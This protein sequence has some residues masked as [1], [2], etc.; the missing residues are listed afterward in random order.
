MKKLKL[1]FLFLLIAVITCSDKEAIASQA[2]DLALQK[3]VEISNHKLVV[4]DFEI[5]GTIGCTIRYA[6]PKSKTYRDEDAYNKCFEDNTNKGPTFPGGNAPKLYPEAPDLPVYREHRALIGYFWN[7][8]DVNDPTISGDYTAAKAKL[9]IYNAVIV[10]IFSDSFGNLD[11]PYD[12]GLRRNK[13]MAYTGILPAGIKPYIDYVYGEEFYL[14][15][16]EAVSLFL[17]H[18]ADGMIHTYT[19]GI[20][21]NGAV[22]GNEKWQ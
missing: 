19:Y 5:G 21:V 17:E 2:T 9:A 14:Q 15:W 12:A 10:S 7:L 11:I 4:D 13:V 6:D 3:H 20:Y 1:L 18:D 8:L 16:Y 22:I